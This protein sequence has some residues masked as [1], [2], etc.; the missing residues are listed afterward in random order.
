MQQVFIHTA[1][2][3]LDQL[4]KLVQVASG[5]GEAKLLIQAGEVQV[6]GETET[7]RGRKLRIGDR[8]EFE[9]EV[10]QLQQAGG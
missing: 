10:F 4:L 5:G 8:V 1:F 9:G 2:I 6:N 7:R 3:R